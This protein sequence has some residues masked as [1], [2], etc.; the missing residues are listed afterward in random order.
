MRPAADR[1]SRKDRRGCRGVSLECVERYDH[2]SAAHRRGSRLL[3][4]EHHMAC[5]TGGNLS[6]LCQPS[7][8]SSNLYFIVEGKSIGGRL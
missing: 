6:F 8:N 5:E 3:F 7:L 1:Y 2:Q 4:R